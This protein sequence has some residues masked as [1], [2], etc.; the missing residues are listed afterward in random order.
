LWLLCLCR[1]R[2]AT[3][4]HARHVRAQFFLM[5]LDFAHQIDAVLRA[6]ARMAAMILAI[7]AFKL[8]NEITQSCRCRL[9]FLVVAVH[10]RFP[11]S[12]RFT[13]DLYCSLWGD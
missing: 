1:M 4:L 9:V 5:C 6:L 11:H 13:L 2:Y 7:M 3:R 10:S 12:V 8:L